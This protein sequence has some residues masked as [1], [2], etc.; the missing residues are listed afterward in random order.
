ML[1]TYPSI[2]DDDGKINKNYISDY[3]EW[4]SDN[5][6]GRQIIVPVYSMMQ[7]KLFGRIV[8]N[9]IVEGKDHWLFT[10]S[11]EMLATYSHTDIPDEAMIDHYVSLFE[12]LNDILKQRNIRFYYFPCYDKVSIY[13]EYYTPGVFADGDC[14][15]ADIF[16][17]ALETNTDI[18]VVDPKPALLSAKSEN[19]D[20]P[21]YFK[22]FDS[23][24]WN[25]KGASIGYE[26]LMNEIDSD[27][28][29]DIRILKEDDYEIYNTEVCADIYG[30]K[31]PYPELIPEATLKSAEASEV[32]I[33]SIKEPGIELGDSYTH[34]YVNPLAEND[35]RILL[36]NDSFVR[37]FLKDNIAES[38]AH[39]LSVN[40]TKLENLETVIDEYDPDIVVLENTEFT[41]LQVME[42]LE[43][44]E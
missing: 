7:Q 8:K 19:A 10:R 40:L 27:C 16:I 37:M 2:K 30:Y 29:E 1:K 42:Y 34:E 17:N 4:L 44:F 12:G 25:W 15:R 32:P 13:P 41:F 18:K 36:I 5:L 38:F 23:N 35:I 3:E 6:R 21:L 33:E 22:S 43:K 26:V 14:S 31:Y 11:E 9:D 20:I 39:T 28:A 24:H